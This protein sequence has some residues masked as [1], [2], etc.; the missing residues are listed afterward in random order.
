[1][2][3]SHG[4]NALNERS[5]FTTYTRPTQDVRSDRFARLFPDLPPLYVDPAILKEIGR[6]GGPMEETDTTNTARSVDVGVVFFG[7]FIDHD[8]TLDVQSSLSSVNTPET[9]DNSRTPT[10][11]LDCIY[12]N[13]PEDSAYLYHHKKGDPFNGVLLL[14]GA[15]APDASVEQQGDLMRNYQNR[16]II[17]DQRNDENRIVSQIQLGMIRFHNAVAR[18]LHEKEE[19]HGRELFEKTRELTTW[20][21]QWAILYDFLPTMCGQGIVNDILTKGRQFY[22][23]DEA[24]IPIEFAVAAYRFGHSMVPQKVRVQNGKPNHDLFGPVL[25]PGF[26]AVT[27]PE[28][29]VD[30]AEIFGSPQK[31]NKLDTKMAPILLDL[32]FIN[33]GEKSLAARN[34]L[35][36]QSFLLPAG[37]KVAEKLGLN[38]REIGNVSETANRMAHHKLSDDGTPLWLFLLAEAETLGRDSKSSEKGEGLG[39]VGGRIVAETLIGLMELD[40]RSFLSSN[41]NWSPQ[42]AQETLGTNITTLRQMLTFA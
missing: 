26:S 37:E 29:I 14:T 36:G 7:Q 28:A 22:C 19:I 12:G 32:P 34:M 31:A 10:L 9:N 23:P 41:R 40:N 5:P 30:F 20:I 21:Y 39:P 4:T 1:M 3:H 27:T 6:P 42:N 33:D 2:P 15:D 35:R 24:F 17:G 18:K 8:I 11:D 13:G 25:G 38:K 16:A